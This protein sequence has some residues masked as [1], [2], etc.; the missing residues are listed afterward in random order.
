MH[1]LLFQ[2]KE[3]F[4][5]LRFV[6]FGGEKSAG[7]SHPSTSTA[8]ASCSCQGAGRVEWREVVLLDE[9]TQRAV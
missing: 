5:R 4:A 2:L 3:E 6:S 1:P 8:T 7:T 9:T